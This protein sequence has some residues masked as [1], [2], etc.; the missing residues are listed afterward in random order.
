MGPGGCSAQSNADE[1]GGLVDIAVAMT[2]VV[3]DV[4]DSNDILVV[5]RRSMLFLTKKQSMP[6]L[7]V[8]R[9]Q[10]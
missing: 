7:D 8:T 5:D 3:P 1:I 6:S 9:S 4:N 2:M 10:L